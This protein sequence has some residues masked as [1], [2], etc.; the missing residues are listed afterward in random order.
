MYRYQRNGQ[1]IAQV[2]NGLESLGRREVEQLGGTE[3]RAGYR[4]ITFCADHAS[5]YRITFKA[6]IISRILIP[7]IRFDCH[8]DRYLYKTGGKIDWSDI[9]GPAQSFAVFCN[10]SHSRIRHSQ[11]AA[12]KL[13]DAIVDQFR[14]QTGSRPRID[15]HFPDVWIHL[16]VHNNRATIS[17]DASGGS[18][19]RR[20]Y[21]EVTVPAPMQETLAAAI[22]TYTG[23]DRHTHLLDPMCGSGTLLCEALIFA[24]DIP[25]AY[26]RSHF[27]LQ[28]M[29]DF[30]PLLWTKIRDEGKSQIQNVPQDMIRGSD[31]DQ[32][33]I[34]AAQTNCRRL[35]GG[36]RIALKK[37][38]FEDAHGLER[39][40]VVCNPPYGRRLKDREQVAQLLENFGCFLRERCSRSTAFVY[41]DSKDLHR[42]LPLSPAWTKDLDHGGLKG[43]LAKYKIR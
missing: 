26:L 2:A 37:T 6:R 18:L 16:H 33:A 9:I 13:K 35:P 43:C 41:L 34:N 19:H 29:P 25:A 28:H 12:L 7:L 15:P 17:L 5:L 36:E 30:D 11:Y 14:E 22:I 3:A 42:H 39:G 4:S 32:Q 23:W 10:L 40:I 1:F 8:S 31:M 20:G 21:R 24:A 38:R 27:G